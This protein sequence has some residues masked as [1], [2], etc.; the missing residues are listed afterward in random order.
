M[1]LSHFRRA[2][3]EG[4]V[5]SGGWGVSGILTGSGDGVG[6]IAF[7]GVAGWDNS[8]GWGTGV[9]V[10]V[11]GVAHAIPIIINTTSSV[12]SVNFF[13]SSPFETFRF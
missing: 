1:G 7:V 2:V 10:G 13:I 4:L 8:V 12:R 11:V 3:A 6:S 5:G 9:G